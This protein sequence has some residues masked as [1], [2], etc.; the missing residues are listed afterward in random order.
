MAGNFGI[1]M[2]D[3]DKTR[4]QLLTEIAELRR[5]IESERSGAEGMSLELA[6]NLS[7]VFE[8]L[9]K[10]SS[11]D[12]LVRINEASEIES[13]TTDLVGGLQCGETTD[14]VLRLA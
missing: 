9:K 1:T 13:I 11:G 14:N 6:I 4:E 12:P 5:L 7:E 2:K 10:I 8:A 3:E